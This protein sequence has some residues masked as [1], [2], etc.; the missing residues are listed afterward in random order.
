MNFLH[1]KF[2]SF[3]NSEAEM[4]RDE[5][6]GK[7]EKSIFKSDK[8]K[9]KEGSRRKTN[10]VAILHSLLHFLKKK[11]KKKITKMKKKMYN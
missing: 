9:V 4:R 10:G 11:K 3:K 5:K 7:K 2:I 6:K 1:D 8:D